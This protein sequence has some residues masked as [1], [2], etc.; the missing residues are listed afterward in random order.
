M[1]SRPQLAK[2]KTRHQP[3]LEFNQYFKNKI[4]SVGKII[5]SLTR[6]NFLYLMRCRTVIPVASLIGYCLR[7]ESCIH[8]NNQ[9]ETANASF[10]CSS[11]VV[12]KIFGIKPSLICQPANPKIN[13]KIN[14]QN[15]FS[16]QIQTALYFVTTAKLILYRHVSGKRYVCFTVHC[17]S[18]SIFRLLSD[19]IQRL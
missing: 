8:L 6:L 7:A 19:K 15:C 1:E 17:I 5:L 2:G 11:P 9:S 16:T 3:R 14:E 10:W 12:Y 18:T 4:C 13:D